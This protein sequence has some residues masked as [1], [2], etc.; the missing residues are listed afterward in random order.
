[1]RHLM[2]G[3]P[4]C[5]LF[6]IFYFSSYLPQ[7]T[8]WILEVMLVQCLVRQV[9]ET[10]LVMSSIGRADNVVTICVQKC[11]Q[12]GSYLYL[13]ISNNHLSQ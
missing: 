10:L 4:A 8:L 7:L 9:V 1:M 3:L 13:C 2:L 12:N 5:C 6:F 11:N